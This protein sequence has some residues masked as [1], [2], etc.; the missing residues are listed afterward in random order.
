MHYSNCFPFSL[1]NHLFPSTIMTNRQVILHWY[2]QSP[3][4]QKVAWALL[5][6][7][8]DFKIVLI[9]PIEPRPLRRP[10]DGGYRKTPI[11][12]I[13]NHTFCDSK[14]IF[15]ELEQRFPEPSFYPKDT[16]GVSSENLIKG[17]ARWTDSSLF[18]LV[19]SQ[20]QMGAL[21]KEFLEDRS[22]FAGR[23]IDPEKLKFTIPFMNQSLKAEI[24]I[25][26]R[27]VSERNKNGELWALG[28]NSL[29]LLDLNFAMITWFVKSLIGK[30]WINA[31]VPVLGHHLE[32]TLKAVDAG[33]LKKI[34]A[35]SPEE[36]LKVAKEQSFGL[37]NATHDGSLNIQLGK[38]VSISPTDSG[39]IPSIG[40]L[41][42]STVNETVIEHKE[43]KYGFTSY[44]HFP[45]VGFVVLPQ[46]S[47]L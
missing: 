33:K 40:V 23:K 8:V 32:K 11:L 44:T 9:T 17:L 25:A 27:F 2:P 26:E 39:I 12:Q 47:K 7:K 24:K 36:A 19:A 41:V 22:K 3:F 29:S 43:E 16:D 15:A 34:E 10:L 5:Y 37:S 1:Y 30:D 20:I 38:L 4:A 42:H 35:I 45:V 21:G 18:S 28:T 31:N 14:I 46:V 13:G 6:K